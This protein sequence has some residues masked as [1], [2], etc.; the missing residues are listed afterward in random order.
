MLIIIIIILCLCWLPLSG[1]GVDASPISFLMV[2][3]SLISHPVRRIS[4]LVFGR[5][6]RRG[7]RSQHPT[8]RSSTIHHNH[9]H[10]HH[11]HQH[12]AGRIHARRTKRFAILA[13]SILNHGHAL[14]QDARDQLQ[15]TSLRKQ[16]SPHSRPS[17]SVCISVFPICPSTSLN[18]PPQRSLAEP[19]WTCSRL[20][21]ICSCK[22]TR[23]MALGANS[24]V[25]SPSPFA[26]FA[27]SVY[28]H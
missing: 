16:P 26:R 9:H 4:L 11:H 17:S 7:R 8:R 2:F 24:T 21:S 20:R 14:A 5:R 25:L 12:S 19:A 22:Q 1:D 15:S 13:S 10:H 23:Y 18:L 3:I 6:A 27:C 28:R